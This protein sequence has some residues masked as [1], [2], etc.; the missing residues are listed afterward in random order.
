VHV[1][2]KRRRADDGEAAGLGAL[3]DGPEQAG[4]ADVG[5]AGDEQQLPGARRCLGQPALSQLK[6]VVAADQDRRLARAMT[7]HLAPPVSK[8]RP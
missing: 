4:L 2:G 8:Y 3:R 5:L 6:D 1:T 7:R